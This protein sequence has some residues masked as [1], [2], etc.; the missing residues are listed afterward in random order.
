MPETPPYWQLLSVL[1]S[2]FPLT[3]SLAMT[4]YEA[5]FDLHTNDKK[6]KKVAGDVLSG[7]VRNLRKHAMLGTIG[8]PT[9]EADVETERGK[10]TIRFLLTRE[11]LETR[12][13]VPKH[14][15]N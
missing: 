15:R 9:F 6:S 4:L 8:G 12:G 10:G 11:G 13:H 5:A 14:L 1:F 7:T 2:S 3:P